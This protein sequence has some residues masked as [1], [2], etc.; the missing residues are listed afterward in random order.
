M[1]TSNNA[2]G[3]TSL[4]TRPSDSVIF[5]NPTYDDMGRAVEGPVN[6]W[7]DRKLEKMNTITGSSILSPLRCV[8]ADNYST[9]HVEQQA[10]S[11]LTFKEQQRSFQVLGYASN[12]SILST[13]AT[14]PGMVGDI[15][16]AY[17]N[18]GNLVSDLVIS[19][20]KTKA[21]KR[22]RKGKGTLGEFEDEDEEEEE[23]APIEDGAV[24]EDG[25]PIIAPLPKKKENIQKEYL[26]PW[27]G[28]E[29][30]DLSPAVPTAEQWEEQEENGGAPL[31]KKQRKQV[32]VDDKSK[33]E[34]GFGQEKSVFHGQSCS[35]QCQLRRCLYESEM[36]GKDLHDY[37]GRSYLHVPT[38]VEVNLSP[39]E[40]GLQE[41]FQPKKCIH[42]WNGHTKGV[43]K[44]Q[45]FPK[46]GH[47]LLSGALDN[48]IKVSPQSS[49]LMMTLTRRDDSS[50]MSI[51]KEN[52]CELLW[53]IRRV[54]ETSRST[55]TERDS[56]VRRLIVR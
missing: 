41:C 21:T 16:Q 37:L 9:G 23:A 13:S 56:S 42:T 32:V 14:G 3:S 20:A 25:E 1:Q 34:V 53:V 15:H 35:Y 44:I 27:A 48:R 11:D 49:R 43:S 46:S 17:L 12:P 2:P 33:L 8:G 40:P 7:S 29:D 36:T 5:F 39:S 28:W 55:T 18:G 54:F 51:T 47:L 45:L 31:N 19:R 4:V 52:V 50:G 30:E 38:D 10:F 6:P 22:K 24:G 26:G